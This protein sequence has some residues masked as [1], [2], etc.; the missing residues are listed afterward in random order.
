M[1]YQTETSYKLSMKDRTAS[2]I[3]LIYMTA[4]AEMFDAIKYSPKLSSVK[5]DPG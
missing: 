3:T 1:G 4:N 5:D 2:T